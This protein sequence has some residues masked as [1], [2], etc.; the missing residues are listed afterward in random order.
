MSFSDQGGDEDNEWEESGDVGFGKEG[1]DNCG[2][3]AFEQCVGCGLANEGK[4][5]DEHQNEVLH[6]LINDMWDEYKSQ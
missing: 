2:L 3:M 5:H 6:L 4:H 1:R